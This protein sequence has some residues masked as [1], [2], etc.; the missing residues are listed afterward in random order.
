MEQAKEMG[1]FYVVD[2]DINVEAPKNWDKSRIKFYAKKLSNSLTPEQKAAYRKKN[3]P[4]DEQY[5]TVDYVNPG[6]DYECAEAGASYR[7]KNK[8]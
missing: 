4:F 3:I 2:Y 8:S 6:R 1:N 7:K 5:A